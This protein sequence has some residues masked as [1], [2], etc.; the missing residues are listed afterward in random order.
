MGV[1]TIPLGVG[2]THNPVKISPF[3]DIQEYPDMTPSGPEA[4]IMTE[5]GLFFITEDD[6]FLTTE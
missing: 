2:I 5:S 3:V 6:V 1:L 4:N